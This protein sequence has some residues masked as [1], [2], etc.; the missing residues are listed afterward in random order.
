M[1]KKGR[2]NTGRIFIRNGKYYF[3]SRINGKEKT[4]SLKIDASEPKAQEKAQEKAKEL[5]PVINSSTREEIAAHVAIAKRLKKE[6][7]R[8]KI[9]KLW[10][11]FEK[12]PE[13]P[14]CGI[15]TLTNHNSH[16]N[17]FIDWLSEKHPLVI[18]VEEIDRDIAHEYSQSIMNMSPRSYNSYLGTL[19]LLFRLI[20]NKLP[21]NQ[22]PFANVLK[23]P[24]E[25]VSKEDFSEEQLQ[26][27]FEVFESETKLM[28]QQEMEILFYLGAYTGLRLKDDAL[29]EWKSFNLETE[30]ISCKPMKTKK[31][32]KQVIIPMHPVLKEKLLKASEWRK[33][34]SPYILP[35]VA[36]RYL[37]NASGVKKDTGRVLEMAGIIEPVLKKDSNKIKERKKARRKLY[38]FHSLRHSFV[39]FCARA[40]VPLAVV[41]ALVGQGSP[42]VTRVY[43]H[44]GTDSFKKVM[45]ALP[46]AKQS[47]QEIEQAKELAELVDILKKNPTLINST[48]ENV[49]NQVNG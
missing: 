23:R 3:R 11:I 10:E 42:A 21:D 16:I 20:Q 39:S 12:N 27:I 13:R 26:A 44:I 4:I 1:S 32:N 25:T 45:N 19:K 9:I 14:S 24:R 46:G 34:D 28:H 2:K 17:H 48:L 47:K 37:Y 15:G 43:T 40:G 29:A 31:S 5:I 30:T 49:K 38:G 6:K 33:E 36:E 7:D 18:Y 8:I 35:N 41:Q 22:S